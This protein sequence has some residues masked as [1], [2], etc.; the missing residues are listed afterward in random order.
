MKQN[1]Q[2]TESTYAQ[3]QLNG[4]SR[5]IQVAWCMSEVNSSVVCCKLCNLQVG[6]RQHRH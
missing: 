4:E 6:S 5:L 3:K 2:A 1:I